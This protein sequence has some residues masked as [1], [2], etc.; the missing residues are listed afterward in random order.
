MKEKQI[1]N[2]LLDIVFEKIISEIDSVKDIG[3]LTGKAGVL[4]FL[5]KYAQIMKS[6]PAEDS[7]DTIIDNL[8]ETLP[9]RVL[10]NFFYTG[11][12]GIVWALSVLGKEKILD[13]DDAVNAYIEPID[14]YMLREQK[15]QVPVLIDPESGLFTSGIYLLSRCELPSLGLTENCD[16]REQ[17]IYLIEDC[18]RILYRKTSYNNLFLPAFTFPLL[19]SV[20]Y[21]LVKVHQQ[22]IYPYKTHILIPYTYQLIREVIADAAIQDV[23]TAYCLLSEIREEFSFPLIDRMANHLSQTENPA[24]LADSGLYALLYN[25]KSIFHE[26]YSCMHQHNPGYVTQ[27]SGKLMKDGDIPVKTLLGIGYGL[28]AI[29]EEE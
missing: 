13:I 26:V 22:R 2:N 5:Y 10:S 17:A 15:T 11:H 4:L 23:M 20:L 1:Q 6:E 27:L 3:L 18:E 28:L 7:A 9:Q 12:S 19:N 25:N 24:I 14:F 8:W 29:A 16:W 21:F